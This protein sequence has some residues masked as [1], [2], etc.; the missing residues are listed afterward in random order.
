MFIVRRLARL[1]RSIQLALVAVA[2]FA[3]G[4]ATVA[5]AS[6]A[7]IPVG[8]LFY[9][10]MIN[11]TASTPCSTATS[12]LGA[13]TTCNAVVDSKGQVA[14]SDADT[15]QALGRLQY[16]NSGNLRVTSQGTSTVSG[17]VNVDNLPATQTVNGTVSV[18]NLPAQQEVTGTVSVGNLPTD[19]NG[20]LKVATQGAAPGVPTATKVQ[21]FSDS[22]GHASGGPGF[23][24]SLHVNMNVTFISIQGCSRYNF[25][26]SGTGFFTPLS[27]T[28]NG[29]TAFPIPLG[30][31]DLVVDNEDQV[32]D[33]T[34]TAQVV[35]Y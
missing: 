11:G 8:S 9:L 18:G 35:G 28:S 22:I 34:Y 3:I 31:T 20:N 25:Y 26:L 2:A 32:F 5:A 1:S 13:T 21:Y 16:D 10:P 6:T 33:C 30:V 12:T 19:A 24:R 27:F 4:S 17:H 7:G 14:I 29:T 23:S 15:H